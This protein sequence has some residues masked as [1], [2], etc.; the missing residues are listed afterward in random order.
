MFTLNIEEN[1]NNSF[2]TCRPIQRK[3]FRTQ[4]NTMCFY[5]ETQSNRQL[6]YKESFIKRQLK[7]MI[8][9]TSKFFF[10]LF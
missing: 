7:T 10:Q 6:Q 8:Q 2:I 9:N 3:A 1:K 4:L 5:V